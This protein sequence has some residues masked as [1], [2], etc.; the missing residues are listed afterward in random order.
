[1]HL[2]LNHSYFVYF[3]D[4]GHLI[5]SGADNPGIV[6]K[7]TSLLANGGLNIDNFETC[8][9]AAPFGG[10]TLFHMKCRVTGADGMHVSQIKSDL[11]QLGNSLNCD[12]ILQEVESDEIYAH[13]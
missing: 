10:T 12:I 13:G 7:I 2:F 11:E 8:S 9:D 3:S 4:V 5:L 6:H 1:M